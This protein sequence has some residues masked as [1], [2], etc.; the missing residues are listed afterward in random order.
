MKGQTAAG[1]LWDASASFGSNQVGFFIHN[2][3]NASLGPQTPDQFDPG[4]Y[5]QRDLNVNLDVSYAFNEML[6][7]A[8]GAE[9][10]ELLG[11]LKHQGYEGFFSLEPHLQVAGR[12]FGYTGH[13][14]FAKAHA[15]LMN[16]LTET[17]WQTPAATSAS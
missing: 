16:L 7:V 14:L 6:H 8:G 17:G 15:A 4:L 10:R 13:D 5:R 11:A 12:S 2:T 1:L 3:V 9:W